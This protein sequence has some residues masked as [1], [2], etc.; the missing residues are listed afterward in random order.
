MTLVVGL[1][2]AF[3]LQLL[4]ANL[5]LAAGI[6]LLGKDSSAVEAQASDYE[7]PSEE[8]NHRNIGFLLGCATLA[9]V[10]LALFTACFLAVRL[11][12]AADALT[13]AVLGMVI[14][15]A[16]LLLLVWLGSSAIGVLL[17]SISEVIGL[18]WQGLRTIIQFI[19][20]RQ[21]EAIESRLQQQITAELAMIRETQQALNAA[22][23]DSLQ[24]LLKPALTSG[25]VTPP[26]QPNLDAEIL[27]FLKSAQANE[28]TLEALDR[29]LQQLEHHPEPE[30]ANSWALDVKPLLR[31]VRSRV[32]LSD[33]DVERV[34]NYI[35]EF[36][37][38]IGETVD[39]ISEFI[40][41]K[42]T[43]Q[44]DV[45]EF[46][47]TTDLAQLH[48]KRLK[49]EFTS[50]IY[51]AEADPYL[52]S[53]Q[54]SQLTP[55]QL[56][57]MLQ[58]RT[59]LSV[60]K[61]TKIVDRLEVV[62]QEVLETVNTQIAQIRFQAINQPIVDYLRTAA[63]TD[64]K[65]KQIHKQLKR[66]L[67]QSPTA[68][69][70]W[71]VQLQHLKREFL[72]QP[73]ME[74]EDLD[75]ETVEHVLVQ[76]EGS[77][78]RL[79]TEIQELQTQVQAEAEILWQDWLNYLSQSSEK[80]N[81]QNIKRQLKTLLKAAKVA[82]SLVKPYLPGYDRSVI[83]QQLTY[84]E[85]LTAKQIQQVSD[86]VEKVWQTI[87]TPS[88]LPQPT[89]SSLADRITQ[90][91]TD[92]LQQTVQQSDLTSLDL[93]TVQQDLLQL[94]KS[95]SVPTG[96]SSLL[97]LVDW[98]QVI[99]QI[100]EQKRLPA[101]DTTQFI[102]ILQQ[103]IYSIS[104]PP[105]RWAIRAQA[106]IQDTAVDSMLKLSAELPE[107]VMQHV[108][109]TRSHLVQQV[110]QLQLQAQQRVDLLKHQAQQ[111]M[112]MARKTAVTAA[113]WLFSTALTSLITSAIAGFL[114]ATQFTPV[115]MP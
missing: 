62:R 47:L 27:N 67:E 14:W 8:H 99:R 82:P 95:L 87:F 38:Q 66:H 18:G 83:E 79:I 3:A 13:G 34:I 21:P 93:S 96:V 73:L 31:A 54:L 69:D 25:E 71:T 23:L 57:A 58:Q 84:R 50:V 24:T 22:N 89:I 59:D 9:S 20:G 88:D 90:T 5:G 68:I 107:A 42:Q 65:P 7:P 75:S 61:L 60:K 64:F 55:D 43:I 45:E 113:W 100:T 2:V 108:D 29:R 6:T 30:Q 52:V 92:Y 70:E 76:L 94:V 37:Q 109:Q 19:L 63:L 103:A 86:R 33:L 102:Q 105:R 51:D 48:R 10:N 104:K 41:P 101:A 16:Y 98:Q 32:D 81:T 17:G 53:Q 39:K 46:L 97:T 26:S 106:A 44:D 77:R 56:T 114:A 91:L 1:L 72:S 111:Q 78:D 4:L 35:R 28:L 85:D 49:S 40:L 12:L 112:E 74:R 36:P 110:E 11:S 15:S 80:L 115:L